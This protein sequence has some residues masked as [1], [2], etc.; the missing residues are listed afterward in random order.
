[1]LEEFDGVFKLK[2]GKTTD[3]IR[4]PYGFHIL[5]VVDKKPARIMS[6]EES[7]KQI[8]TELLR[9]RQEEAFRRWAQQIQ[10]HS[11][12]EINHENFAQIN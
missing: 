2:T 4:T 10:E 7:K 12:I 9:Q 8:Q 1:M 5:K 3:V 6:F 11:S